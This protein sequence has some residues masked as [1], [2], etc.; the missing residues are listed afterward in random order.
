AE[1]ALTPG[2]RARRMRAGVWPLVDD[3]DVPVAPEYLESLGALGLQPFAVSRWLNRTAVRATPDVLEPL[4]RL[5]HVAFLSPVARREPGKAP[6][7][8]GVLISSHPRTSATTLLGTPSAPG[9][10]AG[11]LAQIGVTAL[12]DAGH[13]GAGVLI[14]IMDQGFNFHWKHDALRDRVFPPGFR[15]DFV[16]GD[17]TV[18][19]TTD[20][21]NFR[22]GTWI[23][24]ALGANLPGIYQG[25]AFDATFALARSEVG[26]SE[27]PVEM[28]YWAQAAEW[29]DS[30]GAD[31][32]ASSVGYNDFDTTFTD[33]APADLD[34]RTSDISRAAEIAAS[35]GILLVN[36]VGNGGFGALPRL[37]AP[38]DVHGD[39]LIAVGSVDTF[40]NVSSFSSRG[41]TAD[42]RIKP[43]LVARGTAAWV[44][45][46]NGLP[47]AY[48]LRDGTSFAAPLVAG[49]AACLMQARPAL[50]AVEVIRALRETASGMCAP[51]LNQGWGIPNGPAALAW[52]PGPAGVSGPP[53]GY[54]DMVNTG[55]NPI[56]SGASPLKLR[57][58]LGQRLGERADARLRVFDAQGRLVRG[59]FYGSLTCG[60]WQTVE[61]NG[62]DLQ[63][64]RAGPGVYF[65]HFDAQGRTRSLRVAL[66]E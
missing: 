55:A 11:Q 22:H 24:G 59:L 31:L 26:A 19:D 56:R 18:A 62:R 28:L 38:A 54:L 8:D 21:P 63:G 37:A 35:K 57:F 34:G 66:L 7:G 33:L 50:S 6:A 32:I 29:A 3:R 2:S 46:A 58:G 60:R 40:G 12:H 16:D 27:T 17:T 47:S 4:A 9:L 41:P 53:S 36:S 42:G 43:D 45:H 48:E 10:T 13:T 39:S 64:R 14:A 51:D 23:L 20:L 65:V 30:L 15:R 52:I 25:S 5:P 49:L 44:V 61:W 1:A